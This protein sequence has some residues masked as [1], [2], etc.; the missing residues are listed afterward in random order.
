VDGGVYGI[1]ESNGR[2]YVFSPEPW[3]SRVT[4]KERAGSMQYSIEGGEWEMIRPTG[5]SFRGDRMVDFRSTG[6]RV[7]KKRSYPR[8]ASFRK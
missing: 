5:E 8:M 1:F 4:H 2:T 7:L 6:L 3:F